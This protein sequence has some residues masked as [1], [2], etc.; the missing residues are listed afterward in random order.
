MLAAIFNSWAPPSILD[1]FARERHPITER[2]SRFVAEL[3]VQLVRRLVHLAAAEGLP[4]TLVDVDPR[5]RNDVYRHSLLIVPPNLPGMIA[6]L[7][8][9][10][11][12]SATAVS[13]APA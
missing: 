7:R 4:L 13:R 3:G 1:A 9:E 5:E 2:V 6:R 11:K 12:V 8:G 10:T